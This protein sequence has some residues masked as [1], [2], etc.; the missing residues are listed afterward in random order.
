MT[1]ILKLFFKQFP[2]NDKKD[3]ESIQELV[4]HTMASTRNRMKH[5]SYSA[6]SDAMRVIRPLATC[7]L[8][9]ELYENEFGSAE[10]DE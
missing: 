3:D 7:S 5:Y 8:F 10:Q 6:P 4:T 1:E 2:A 9:N